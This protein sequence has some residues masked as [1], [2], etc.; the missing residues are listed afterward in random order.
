M[1]LGGQLL[2]RGQWLFVWDHH[3]VYPPEVRVRVAGEAAQPSEERQT[4]RGYYQY[5]PRVRK[6]YCPW[7]PS[8]CISMAFSLS[9]SVLVSPIDAMNVPRDLC[10]RGH[11]IG[12]STGRA[13]NTG[14][15][16]NWRSILITN[17][18]SKNARKND[19]LLPA[20]LFLSVHH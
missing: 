4:G 1:G 5:G 18:M 7:V 11:R 19:C 2:H 8:L 16:V 15:A 6:M 20:A 13:R 3:L 9:T 17:V 10:Q 14:G 12:D